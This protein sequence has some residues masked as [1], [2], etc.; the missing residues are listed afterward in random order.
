MKRSLEPPNQGFM[1]YRLRTADF[2]ELKVK[3][4]EECW[5]GETGL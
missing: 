5:C 2:K 1:T 4:I 3:R